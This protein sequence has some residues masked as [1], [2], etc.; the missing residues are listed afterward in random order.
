MPS[1]SP[2][3]RYGGYSGRDADGPLCRLMTHSGLSPC[4]PFSLA[5]HQTREARKTNMG[6]ASLRLRAFFGCSVLRCQSLEH[7]GILV[8]NDDLATGKVEVYAMQSEKS[9]LLAL[10]D[11]GECAEVG[12][13]RSDRGKLE[14]ALLIRGGLKFTKLHMVEECEPAANEAQFRAVS[15]T[16]CR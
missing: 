15:L 9:F 1:H 10:S 16:V 5:S 6:R 3:V 12:K 13:R 8:E 11:E 7:P 2:N 4:A 14:G